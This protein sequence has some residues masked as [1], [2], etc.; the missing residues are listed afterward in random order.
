MVAFV[1]AVLAI[2][3]L[4]R[5]RRRIWL[6]ALPLLLLATLETLIGLGQM[7]LGEG[8]VIARGSYANRN[9]FAGLMEMVLP[10]A[11]LWV[12]TSWHEASGL[13]RG[14]RSTT[15]VVRVLNLSLL[16]V[17]ML[18]AVVFSL[19]RMG[20]VATLFGVLVAGVLRWRRRRFTLVVAALVV[21]GIV[22]LPT[23]Q[24]ISRFGFLQD[25][26]DLSSD[27]RVQIWKESL[28][29]VRDYPLFGCGL[30]AYEPTFV[31]YQRV[32]PTLTVN[33]AHND[34]LQVLG[35]TGVVGLGLVLAAVLCLLKRMW[36]AMRRA[37]RQEDKPARNLVIACAAATCAMGLH[38]VV[39]F[40]LYTPANALV[41]AWI[42]GMAEGVGAHLESAS[43]QPPQEKRRRR[44]RSRRA[45]V[46]A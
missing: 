30:G 14:H 33:F 1:A 34:Y 4:T 44:E 23:E 28:D 3:E 40:N 13:H 6:M 18:A 10:F 9:H 29:L 43:D 42:C 22:F 8:G 26:A 2:R 16:G 31:K 41:F 27:D 24:L 46:A 19:S 32:A 39:D 11:F 5:R 25:Q 38:S 15:A 35:E 20:F 21:A 37:E 45:A 7:A 12:V 17:W 36:S